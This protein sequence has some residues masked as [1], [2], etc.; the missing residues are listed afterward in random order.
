MVW[1]WR[2]R[3]REFPAACRRLCGALVVI[4][5]VPALAGN[6]PAWRGPDGTG[7]AHDSNV[8]L[9]WS[10]KENVCWR[11]PLPDR[12]NSTPIVWGDRV[13]VTQAIEKENRRTVMCFDRRDGKLL[14]QSGITWSERDP[15]NGQN[16]YCSPS[17]VTDGQRV[18]AYFG[19][20]GLYCYDFAGK[21]LWHRETGKVDSWQGSGSSPILYENLCILNAG[22]GTHAALIA[23]DKRTGEV[24]WQVAPPKVPGGAAPGAPPPA[25]NGF[26][27]AMMSADP[28]GE[29]GFLGSW[30]TPLIAHVDERDELIVVHPLQ[31]A[32]YEPLT[33]KQIWRCTGLPDQA[34]A[35]PAVGEG[36]L[37]TT[38]HRMAGGGTRVTAIKLGGSGDITGTNRLWQTDL[39]KECVGSGIITAGHVFLVTQFGSVVC[40]D[41]TTGKKVWEKRLSGQGTLGG[42]WSS[43]VLLD[44]KLLIP[45]HSGEVFILAAAPRFEWLGINWAGEE[46]TC[47]SPAIADGE[48]F[49]RTYKA[50][51]CF[52]KPR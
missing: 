49:L 46:T 8:P 10:E 11:T 14:W 25:H 39:P 33:G 28:T 43:I 32:G 5:T 36:V 13:F 7:V 17:P 21:E 19:S 22:P 38:G 52:G 30:A 23:V 48:L 31:V 15:T 12:G 50:L 29:G 2:W 18:I 35:S 44:D 9:T 41:L 27:G 26:D 34:F 1:P 20:P 51:W 37:V 40:V 24:V 16:P 45:N 47:A 42:S 6:W 3:G 4:A